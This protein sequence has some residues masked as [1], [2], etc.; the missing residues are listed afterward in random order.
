VSRNTPKLR[1]NIII[2]FLILLGANK[3]PASKEINAV[4]NL[5]IISFFTLTKFTLGEEKFFHIGLQFPA[6][7]DFRDFI[8]MQ[9]A[10]VDN[11]FGSTAGIMF[12]GNAV[13]LCQR[14]GASLFLITKHRP[15]KGLL[16]FT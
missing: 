3:D 4:P 10:K 11:S 15:T 12:Y 13:R 5:A 6:N 1:L 14:C 16:P 7:A 8:E 9:L 2:I